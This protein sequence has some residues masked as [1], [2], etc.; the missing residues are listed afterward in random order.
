MTPHVSEV[1][2]ELTDEGRRPGRARGK[3]GTPANPRAL[4]PAGL[5]RR[6]AWHALLPAPRAAG[7]GCVTRRGRV[8]YVLRGG[9]QEPCLDDPPR[10][11][12]PP[13]KLQTRPGSGH[14]CLSRW[15]HNA[16]PSLV[17]R[18]PGPGRYPLTATAPVYLLRER[19]PTVG[20][21]IRQTPLPPRGGGSL[22]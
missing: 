12:S 21:D 14:R 13:L 8:A 7:S 9:M 20:A 19:G 22:S 17:F 16:R 10:A 3:E 1:G 6:L 15:D 2:V 5:S 4:R 18:A 11:R